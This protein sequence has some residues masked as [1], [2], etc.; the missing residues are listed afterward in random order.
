MPQALVVPLD[1]VPDIVILPAP[2]AVMFEKA[3]KET[4][5][6]SLPVPNEVPLTVSEPVLIVT[7]ASPVQ[8]PKALPPVPRAAV[9]VIV[10]LPVPVAEMLAD[11]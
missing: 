6:E 1:E 5:L 4:P 7:V 10:T 11:E 9:P 2:V 8:M 3:E